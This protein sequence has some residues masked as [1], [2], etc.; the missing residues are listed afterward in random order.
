MFW[1]FEKEEVWLEQ[2]S[3]S[4]WGLK[5]VSLGFYTFEQTPPE[6]MVYKIDFRNFKNKSDLDDYVALFSDSGWTCVSPKKSANIFYFFAPKDCPEKGIFSDRTSKAQRYLRYAQYLSSSLIPL[7]P[8]YIVLYT[9]KIVQVKDLG[10]QTPGLWN[11]TGGEFIFH[12]LFETP[13]VVFRLIGGMLPIFILL[14][15]LFFIG[16]YYRAYRKTI[17][18]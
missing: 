9:S 10:Y 12:F 2:M 11:M 15:G 3:A 6:K 7:F 18:E 14:V 17:A 16:L 1:N 5:K 8:I 13:F 4:G